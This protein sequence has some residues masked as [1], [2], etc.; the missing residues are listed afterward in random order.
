MSTIEAWR[1]EGG[2]VPMLKQNINNV[3]SD[4]AAAACDKQLVL[5]C[6]IYGGLES[7]TYQSREPLPW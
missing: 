7:T 4:K 2:G 3:S 1:I 6:K 5:Y